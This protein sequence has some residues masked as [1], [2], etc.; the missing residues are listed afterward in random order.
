MASSMSGKM[1]Q[2]LRCD[3][4]PERARWRYL[5]LRAVYARKISPNII[6]LL[7][8]IDTVTTDKNRTLPI[9]SHRNRASLVN[10]PYM[11]SHGIWDVLIANDYLNSELA[12]WS[13]RLNH[14]R[15]VRVRVLAEAIAL[16]R[17]GRYSSLTMPLS[18]QVFIW[19]IL[20]NLILG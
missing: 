5:E 15:A 8:F 13:G 12:Y 20:A 4:R 18:K 16:C 2:I 1:N 9:S 17:W 7:F 6:F 19:R 3:W 11:L 14:G 10:N